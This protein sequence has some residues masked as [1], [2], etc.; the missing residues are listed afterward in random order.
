MPIK[1]CSEAYFSGFRFFNELEISDPQ[2]KVPTGGLVL[3]MFTSRK[4]P[5]TSAGFELANLGSRGEHVTP[6]PTRP[7]FESFRR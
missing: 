2:L 7:T 6:R 5:S 3:R 1:F 4:N